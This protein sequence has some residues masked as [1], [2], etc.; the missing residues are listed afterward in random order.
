MRKFYIH[1]GYPKTGTTT[2]QRCVFDH[3]HRSG[4]IFYLGMFGFRDDATTA[5]RDFFHNITNA[6]Y[7][8]APDFDAALPKLRQQLAHLLEGVDEK[9]PVVLSNEHFAQSQGSTK[10][11]GLSITP[12]ETFPRL[13]QI[14]DGHEVSIMLCLR[15]QDDLAEALF[16][17]HYSRADN[18]TFSDFGGLKGFSDKVTDRTSL[19]SKCFDFDQ[20]LHDLQTSFPSSLM[21][22]WL[23]EEFREDNGGILARIFDFM[24][25]PRGDD[26]A[27][28][29]DTLNIKT[30]REG[31]VSPRAKR[32]V[33][34]I[35][36]DAARARLAKNS[37]IKSQVE[38]LLRSRDM[39]TMSAKEKEAILRYWSG[40]NSALSGRHPHLQEVMQ[41]FGYFGF[42]SGEASE[43]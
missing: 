31:H 3:L 5:R 34:L 9:T 12:S 33:R 38:R 36:P 21:L 25:I 11:E 17:E 20:V 41:R 14:F 7:L 42:A 37:V 26:A 43:A 16:L 28:K 24:K 8:A 1:L 2:L 32:L 15:R 30:G 19:L 4:E 35:V 39:V 6:M 10:T 40:S 29:L 13:A 22:V 27:M 23:F 18:K